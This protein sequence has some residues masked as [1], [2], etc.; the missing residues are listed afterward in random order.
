MAKPAVQ[1]P[2]APGDSAASWEPLSSLVDWKDNPK[3]HDEDQLESICR[4]VI[5]GGWGAPMLARAANREI[6]AGHGRKKAA[7]LLATKRLHATPDEIAT[8]HADA[9]RVAERQQAPTRFVEVSEELAHAMA[10]ADNRIPEDGKVDAGA[11]RL[12]V[13]AMGQELATL[14]GFTHDEITDML[15]PPV[16]SELR[17]VDVSELQD[18]YWISITGPMPEQPDALER[19]REILALLPEALVMVGSTR[20]AT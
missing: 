13:E 14:A 16:E 6:I 15:S 10:L 19:V 11:L 1:T 8:W 3:E 5:A 18:R 2:S 20:E 7:K 12:A 9:I 17:E 4:I